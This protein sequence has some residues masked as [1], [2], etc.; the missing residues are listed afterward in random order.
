VAVVVF[1]IWGIFFRFPHTL[2]LTSSAFRNGQRLPV[3][4]TCDGA[5][6][7][8]PLTIG[9][10]PA[11]AKGYAL[12]FEDMSAASTVHWLIWNIPVD[13]SAILQAI[14]PEGTIARSYD[15]NFAY[16]GPCPPKGSEHRYRIQ[17]YALAKEQLSINSGA[18]LADFKAAISGQVIDQAVLTT[19]YRRGEQ[20]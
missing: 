8:P 18:T 5:N 10:P 16:A 12:L 9:N 14:R 7:N 13:Q 3:A 6:V 1:L 4:F 15:G 11:Q 2:T 17:V 20:Q 19:T